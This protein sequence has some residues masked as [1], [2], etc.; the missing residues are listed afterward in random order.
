MR[1][2]HLPMRSEREKP[3]MKIVEIN[4]CIFG[5]TGKIMADIA[6]NE[7]KNGNSVTV[8]FP[9]S[10]ENAKRNYSGRKIIIGDRV[11]RNLHL[12]LAR[13]TGYG[14]CFSVIATKRFLHKLDAVHPDIIH[15]HNL[16]NCYINLPML[17]RYIKKR[18]IPVVWTLHDCWAFTGQ[19]PHFSMAA[20][21]KWETGCG[22]CPQ[23]REYPEARVDRTKTMFRLKKKW[24]TGVKK[25]TVVTPSEWLAGLVRRSFLGCYPVRVIHNGIDL[26]VFRPT[27][28]DFREKH[29]I[30]DEEKMILGVAFGWGKRKGLD[31]FISLASRL[32]REEYRIVLV[33]TDEMVE[34]E[35]PEGIIP[36][37][38]THSREE[39]A[40]IYTAA[41]VLVNPTREDNYPTVNMEAEACGTPVITFRTG[42][43]PESVFTDHGAVVECDDIGGTEREIRR[44]CSGGRGVKDAVAAQAEIFDAAKCFEG[45]TAIYREMSKNSE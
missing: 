38:R 17:F 13:M 30:T 27:P 10:R 20:C 8:C 43:S 18:G 6:A 12:F 2:P 25:L 14:G 23:F 1:P 21:G 35:L 19:C 22:G 32:K 37:R 11:S 15:L 28:S 36:V 33:G 29:G 34:A 5:S 31:V 44:I 16:H 26:S 9:A 7:E 3:I 41:D 42:G 40:A 39:L 4:S 24:F 45:Y